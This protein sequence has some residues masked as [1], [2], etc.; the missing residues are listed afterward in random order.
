MNLLNAFAGLALLL[1][2]S[3]CGNCAGVELSRL[4]VTERESGIAAD[5]TVVL[6]SILDSER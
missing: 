6:G 1:S 2:V 3:G 5:E 4:G